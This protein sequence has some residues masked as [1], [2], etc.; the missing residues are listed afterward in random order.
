MR[1][2]IL[3]CGYLGLALGEALVADGHDV[4][5][6]RRSEGGL[7]AVADAGVEPV[8]ADVTDADDLAAVP[9][10]DALAFAASAGS[11]DPDAAR[12]AYVDGLRTVVD[13]FGDRSAPPER[14]LYAG[15][16]GVYG[17]RGGDRVDEETPIEPATERERVLAEAERVA[18]EEA[19]AVGI[20]GTAVRFGGIY[21]PGRFRVERYLTRPVTEGYLNVIHR[22]D[23]AGVL[24]FLLAGDYRP[25][26]LVAVDDEPV[27]KPDF[28]AWLAEEC[29]TEPPPTRTREEYLAETDHGEA[30]RRRVLASKRCSNARLRSLGYELAYPTIRDGYR[31]AVAEWPGEGGGP[32]R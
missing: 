8:R 23:A 1:V 19:G 4:V 13:H 31:E 9:D 10:A 12:A 21:G 28:A 11:R 26:R 7:D 5:G 16:T 22:S 20:D 30:R 15:S 32:E 14:L 24:R 17:D 25:D 6:V 18:V 3:G 2:A 29:G 27:W